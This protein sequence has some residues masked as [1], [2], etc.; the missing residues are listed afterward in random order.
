MAQNETI[1]ASIVGGSGY[2][3]GELLRLLLGH[4]NINVQ[5]VT[6]ES[7]ANKFVKITHP[8]LRKTTT[9]KFCSV[10]EL[11]KCDVLF[12]C[13]PHGMAMKRID[14]FKKLAPRIIDLSGDFRLNNA[15]DYDTWY[16]HPHTNPSLLK[17]FIYGIPELHR[18]KMQKATMISS[19]GCNATCTILGLYPLVK[20]GV[21]DTK[22]PIVAESKCGSSE[23]G[24][25]SSLA[26]HHPERTNCVRSYKP[27]MHRHCAEMIQE[28]TTGNNKLNINFSATSIQLVRGILTTSHV[29]LKKE[30]SEK[31]I[32]KIYR[33]AY[34]NEP[35]IRIVK[36]KQGIYRYPEPK[37]LA[38]TNYCDVGFE[39]DPQSRRVVVISAID[40]LMKGAAGQAVQGMNIMFGWE[41]SL[42]LEFPGLHPV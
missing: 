7:N 41:E 2:A 3:G 24:N 32:W 18:E 26:S 27:T 38:G 34:S 39:V 22:M 35:F 4:P 5:Q 28:L 33:E 16:N 11:Q 12:L 13:L 36:E 17:K 1:N 6:S 40:N 21:I 8:N 23:G 30:M 9:L 20:A 29:F 25:K 14:Q 37:I 31:D 19:A 10:K 42:G 15:K